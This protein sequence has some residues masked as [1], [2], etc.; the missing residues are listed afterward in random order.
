MAKPDYSNHERPGPAA[1][2]RARA[3]ERELVPPRSASPPT[4]IAHSRHPKIDHLMPDADI[5]VS[6]GTVA[7]GLDLH[8]AFNLLARSAIH[9]R[10]LDETLRTLTEI[11]ARMLI[12][13]RVSL[14]ALARGR[15]AIECLDL[16]QLSKNAH[17]SGEVLDE[18]RYP[19]YFAGLRREETII[20]DDAAT[21]PC[22][23]EFRQDYLLPNGIT[24]ILDTPVHVR[25][26]LQGVLC[27][28]QVGPHGGWTPIQRMFAA[29]AANLV[30]L[31]LVQNEA[32]AAHERLREADGR[33]HALFE[34]S[35]EAIVISRAGD[36]TIVDVNPAATRLLGRPRNELLAQPQTILHP[37]EESAHYGRLFS[38]HVRCNDAEPFACEVVN[39][40]GERI[41][42]EFS[43]R[44]VDTGKGGEIVQG[45]LRPR[46]ALSA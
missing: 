17:A 5:P 12:V 43:A 27:I 2:Q 32:S 26:E 31:A 30:T 20:A 39:A 8:G 44:L 21:H 11:C 34:S 35:G 18:S 7:R 10:P 13:E 33:L 4:T 6:H 38:E 29:A 14:W 41:A 23:F 3:G 28:E 36:G 1:A 40:A 37:E 46:A 9:E 24:A 15:T 19:H 25:G 16:Y 45:I 42:V 22:T